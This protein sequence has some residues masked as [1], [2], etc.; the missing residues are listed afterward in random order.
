M[1]NYKKIEKELDRRKRAA[2]DRYL[3]KDPKVA[4]LENK[5]FDVAELARKK[6]IQ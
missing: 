2:R 3:D 5:L 1:P 6:G 4:E